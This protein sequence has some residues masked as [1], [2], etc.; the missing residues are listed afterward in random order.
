MTM[1]EGNFS[2]ISEAKSMSHCCTYA[3]PTAG[4]M[5]IYIAVASVVNNLA[6]GERDPIYLSEVIASWES[7]R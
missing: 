2:G 5:F 3:T 1:A 6:L 7:R 4:S